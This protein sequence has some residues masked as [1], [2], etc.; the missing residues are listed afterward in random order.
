[1]VCAMSAYSGDNDF[2][3]LRNPDLTK[4]RED[5]CLGV[6]IQANV[7]AEVYINGQ[8]FGKTPVTTLDL[9]PGYYNLELRKSGYDTIKCRIYPRNRYT[10]IYEFE[11]EK[12]KGFINVKNAP[13]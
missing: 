4:R 9:G 3:K 7:E 8:Y 2:S 10:S 6:I 12:V 5:D 13:T 11:M 1:M